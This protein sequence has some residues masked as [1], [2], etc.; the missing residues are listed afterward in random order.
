MFFL[1]LPHLRIFGLRYLVIFPLGRQEPHAV[2]SLLSNSGCQYDEIVNGEQLLP[3]NLCEFIRSSISSYRVPTACLAPPSVPVAR[4]PGPWLQVVRSW[5]LPRGC[6]CPLNCSA[7]TAGSDLARGLRGRRWCRAPESL[8]L[9]HESPFPCFWL[10][11]N[12]TL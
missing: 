6:R 7:V 9:S 11:L 4:R 12:S 8:S 10:C 1:S 5:A 2:T 3:S